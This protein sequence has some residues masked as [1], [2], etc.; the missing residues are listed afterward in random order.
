MKPNPL[1]LLAATLLPCLASGQQPAA[2]K[3]AA[4]SATSDWVT[5]FD[6]TSTDAWRAYGAAEFPKAGW[7]V[8]D[9]AL[10]HAAQGGGGDL[11]SKR[12]FRN[13]ELEFDWRVGQKA[14]SGVMF[15]VVETKEPSYATG[16]EY[17]L[18]DDAGHGATPDTSS[19]ALYALAAPAGAEVR[20]A[21]SWNAA[22]ITLDGDKLAHWLN[23]KKVVDVDFASDGYKAS[24]AKSKFAKWK[25]FNAHP[26]GHI[27]L[28]DHGDEV[29]FRN[30]RIRE[31]PP[32]K[33]RHGDEVVLF[34]GK[35]LDAFAAHLNEGKQLADVW[36]IVDGVLICKGQPAGYLYT[37]ATFTNYVLKVQWRFDPKTGG[38]NSGVL[39]RMMGEH[40]VWPRSIEAQLHAGNAGDFWNIGD[41]TMTTDAARAKGRNTKKSHANEKPLGE[42]NDYEI[43]VDGSWVRLNVNG[44]T[45]NE[46]WGCEE[47]AGPICF[48]SEGVEIQFR[49][50]RLTNLK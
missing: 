8:V 9:G 1:S 44:Q 50:I 37:K 5:L 22:R 38:G 39:L 16:P 27:C 18:L 25:G 29:A 23:G 34:D 15:R 10:V 32:S 36:S 21:S 46:A 3:P 41:F 31:L 4:P 43:I 13:F 47:I 7:S 6:G 28:Q 30:V 48:Q 17:Q 49:D 42:W 40:K 26:R 12:Q 20:P 2:P 14:N 33:S 19:G 24:L 35:S 11:I 45:L